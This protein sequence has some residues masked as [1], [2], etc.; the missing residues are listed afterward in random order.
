MALRTHKRGPAVSLPVRQPGPMPACRPF[1][2]AGAMPRLFPP[3]IVS[4]RTGHLAFYF[5]LIF[6]SSAPFMLFIPRSI[7]IYFL[8][9]RCLFLDNPI[10]CFL[11]PLPKSAILVLS[12]PNRLSSFAVCPASALFYPATIRLTFSIFSPQV[13]SPLPQIQ[14]SHPP[15][16]ACPLSRNGRL[17]PAFPPCAF[18]LRI[19]SLAFHFPLIFFLSCAACIFL[20]LFHCRLRSLPPR[21]GQQDCFPAKA[22]KKSRA[23]IFTCT[24][25]FYLRIGLFYAPTI[26]SLQANTPES[27]SSASALV[28]ALAPP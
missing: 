14:R 15:R 23:G 20:V 17:P 8:L 26:A 27:I 18:S 12:D 28:S 4:L 21:F 7:A 1:E 22:D 5:S 2:N 13:F 9:L 25:F 6:Y 24:A 10:S 11:F 16:K 3:V 19:G